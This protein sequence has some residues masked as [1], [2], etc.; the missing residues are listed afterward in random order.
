MKNK[1][2]L[3]NKSSEVKTWSQYCKDIG[4][5]RQVVNRW[6]EWA[7]GKKEEEN[8]EIER[9]KKLSEEYEENPEKVRLYHGNFYEICQTFENN[10][11]DCIITDPPYPEKY[12]ELWSQLSEIAS[13]K[14]KPGGFCITYSG[15]YHLMGKEEV[16]E[17]LLVH[18]EYYEQIVLIHTG[19]CAMIWPRKIRTGYKSILVYYKPPFKSSNEYTLDVIEGSGREKSLDQWQQSAEELTTIIQSFTQPNDLVLDPFAG[20]GT[21]LIGC[22]QN[23]RRC[24]GI[25]I[26][27][28]KFK[29]I[30]G[31]IIEKEKIYGNEV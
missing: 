16:D 28:E 5:S 2:Q 20:T 4:S 7:F 3:R 6:L 13:E 25:E 15:K 17:R 21:T 11:I 31:R 8:N 27:E 10:S 1:N 22:L 30:K 29:L 23:Q 26:N 24:V 14:L 19:R 9:L 12:L 18:L